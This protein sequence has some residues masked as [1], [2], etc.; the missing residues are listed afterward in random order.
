[1]PK[2]SVDELLRDDAAEFL[3]EL[4]DP[5]VWRQWFSQIIEQVE[6]EGLG[7]VEKYSDGQP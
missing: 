2:R 6:R 5:E 4:D 7:E 1:M 3:K